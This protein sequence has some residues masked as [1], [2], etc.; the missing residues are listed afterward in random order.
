VLF[1]KVGTQWRG[2]VAGPTGLDYNVLFRLMDRMDLPAAEWD[3][4]LD[5]IRTMELQ[6]L[7]TMR[8]ST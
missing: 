2:G 6:A 4:T 8:G 7:K 1:I 5:S 3:E